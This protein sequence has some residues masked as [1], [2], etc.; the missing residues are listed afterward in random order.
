MDWLSVVLVGVVGAVA[1]GFWRA[2]GADAWRWC[3][4][5]LSPPPQEVRRDFSAGDGYSWVPKSKVSEK[6]DLGYQYYKKDRAI[7]YRLISS[8]K[9]FLMKRPTN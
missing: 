3:K 1:I 9:E 2:I 8:G 7:R 6:L 5:K 4:G